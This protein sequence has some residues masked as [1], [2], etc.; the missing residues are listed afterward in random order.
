[1]EYNNSSWHFRA[2]S[3]G[4]GNIPSQ[5]LQNNTNL[6][7]TITYESY[8]I[9]DNLGSSCTGP[10]ST[11]EITVNPSFSASS[12]ISNYNGYNIS[13]FGGNNGFIELEIFGGSGSYNYNWTGPNGYVAVTEDAYN[14]IA[15]DYMVTINDGICP[16]IILNFSLNQPDE[17]LAINNNS[18]LTNVDCFGTATGTLGI[19]ITQESVPPYTFIVNNNGNVIQTITNSYSSTPTFN[20]LSAGIYDIQIIDANGNT[21]TISNLVISEPTELIATTTATPDKL[22][23]F[24]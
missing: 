13:G 22:F 19:S 3:N 17:L 6:P 5:T 11:Y 21:K 8:A 20:G 14:L 10:I 9:F 1:M 12:T 23:W 24:K 4:T 7:L 15:G 18:A 16:P 2:I